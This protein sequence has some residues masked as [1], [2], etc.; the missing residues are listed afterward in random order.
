MRGLKTNNS[1]VKQ[2]IL[3]IKKDRSKKKKKILSP[4]LLKLFF[5]FT[6]EKNGYNPTEGFSG[7]SLKDGFASIFIGERKICKRNR[8]ENLKR[9]D[10]LNFG[11]KISVTIEEKKKKRSMI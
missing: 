4:G 6:S 11:A 7:V 3:D 2:T 1:I 10:T 9:K 5:F 8:H